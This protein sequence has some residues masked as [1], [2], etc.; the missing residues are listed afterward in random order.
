M[1]I[2]PMVIPHLRSG[3][4][5]LWVDTALSAMITHNDSASISTCLSFVNVLWQLLQMD[6]PPEPDWWLET[7]VETARDLEV[8]DT[9]S[10][11]AGAC[12]AH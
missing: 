8:D 4:P 2:A 10:P 12:V 7:C 5:D 3:T 1:R 11:R 9:Y 6:A